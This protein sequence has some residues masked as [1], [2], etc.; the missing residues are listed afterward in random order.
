[1]RKKLNS[2]RIL[3]F[4][5]S[6]ILAVSNVSV[7]HATDTVSPADN[8]A[9]TPEFKRVSIDQT[10]QGAWEGTYGSDAAILLGYAYPGS[11]S[12]DSTTTSNMDFNRNNFNYVY[13]AESCSYF[14]SWAYYKEAENMRAYNVDQDSDTILNMPN[15]EPYTTYNKIES[16]FKG[17]YAT[18]DI[19]GSSV[20]SGGNLSG[21]VG[22]TD[23][24]NSSYKL[25]AYKFTLTDTESHLFSIYGSGI[26]ENEAVTVYFLSENGT[27]LLLKDTITANT[28]D[29]GAYVT[30]QV[31]GSFVLVTKIKGAYDGINGF[32]LDTNSEND[33][34][35]SSGDSGE[36]GENDDESGTPSTAIDYAV[37]MGI[38]TETKGAWEGKY[39][40]DVAVLYGYQAIYSDHTPTSSGN[41]LLNPNSYDYTITK[42]NLSY[43]FT[44]S[45]NCAGALV[46][47][48]PDQTDTAI[49]NMPSGITRDKFRAYAGSSGA[50]KKTTYTLTFD[51]TNPHLVSLYG[52]YTETTGN[53]TVTIID[54]STSNILLTDAISAITFNEGAYVTYLVP[55]SVQIEISKPAGKTGWYAFSGTFIDAFIDNKA[56]NLNA[57]AGT[58]ARSIKLSWTEA[59][60]IAEGAQVIIER[61]S[62]NGTD[63]SGWEQI[64]TVDAGVKEYQDTSLATGCSYTYR[65]TTKEVWAYSLPGSEVSYT[66]ASYASSTLTFTE[67][68]YGAKD[69]TEEVNMVISLINANEEPIS[70][71]SVSV[72]VDFNHDEQDLGSFSTDNVGKIYVDFTPRYL[73][74]ATIKASFGD[75]DETQLMGTEVAASLYVGEKEF[76]SAPVLYRLSDAV[77]PDDLISI[78]GYGLKANDMDDVKIWYAP[79]TTDDVAAQ[80]GTNAAELVKVQVDERDGYFIVTQLPKNAE[81]GLYDIWVQNEYGYSQPLVLNQARPLFISEYEAWNGQ[82]IRLSGRALQ[83]EQ[84]GYA[85]TTKVR[86]INGTQS[87]EQSVEALTPYSLTFRVGDVPLGTYQVEV[88]N[89]NGVTYRGLDSDQTLTV[90]NVGKDPLNIGVAWMDH[91]AWDNQFDVTDYGASGSDTE[92]DTAAINKAIEAATSSEAQ[93]GIIYIPDGTYHIKSIAVPANIVILGQSKT[94]T[95]LT[96]TGTGENMFQTAA[97]SKEIGHN[98]FARFSIRLSVDTT[99]PDAFFWLGQSWDGSQSDVATRKAEEFFLKEIDISYSFEVTETKRGITAVVIGNERYIVQD[100]DFAGYW[101][102]MQDIKVNAYTYYLRNS[103]EYVSA[104]VNTQASYAFIEE[105]VVTGGYNKGYDVH[106]HGIFGTQ[107]AHFENNTVKEVGHYAVNDGEAFC[108]EPPGGYE[109]YGDVINSS[110]DSVTY[111]PEAGV[112]SEHIALQYGKLHIQ[113][114]GG[115][116]MGQMREVESWDIDTNTV[117]ITEDWDVI[118]DS[119]S[120]ISI[121]S[122]LENF[123]VY[124]NQMEDCLKG[125]YFYG[126]VM[127]GVASNNVGKNTEGIYVHTSQVN[128]TRL[129]PCYYISIR[130]NILTGVSPAKQTCNISVRT[131]RACDGADYNGVMGYSVEIRDNKMTGIK[132]LTVNDCTEAPSFSGIILR[133]LSPSET[134]CGDTTNVLVENNYLE[135][136]ECAIMADAGYYG[137]LL[138]GNRIADDVDVALNNG[139]TVGTGLLTE[140]TVTDADSQKAI[141][142]QFVNVWDDVDGTIYTEETY[143]A[144]QN[145][146]TQ[147]NTVLNKEDA[148]SDELASALQEVRIASGRLVY[149]TELEVIEVTVDNVGSETYGVTVTAPTNGWVEGTNTF[150]VSSDNACVV[151][152]KN[153]NGAY[154]RVEATETDTPGAYSYTVDGMTAD[155]EITVAVAGDV[156]GDGQVNA[157]DAVQVRAASLGKITMSDI[158]SLTGDANGDGIINAIDAVMIRATSLGKMSL[159]W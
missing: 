93:G 125:I 88:S 40:N 43:A 116:G 48:D 34:S 123:T 138:K 139:N 111:I 53:M 12:Y 66:I 45:Y 58:E 25:A 18:E 55:G 79:H 49:L 117:K 146:I 142:A 97:E 120:R 144:L 92:D 155:T 119:T 159:E 41:V 102:S 156:N 6:L 16:F 86:L 78:N 28:F 71:Q 85:S 112:M 154:T 147:A 118:P 46:C 30:Y 121:N 54:Q 108:V 114:V 38:D 21:L 132:G 17:Q 100:C 80:P 56:D 73:G 152:V 151:A 69:T 126:Y 95:I 141:L 84:F 37:R 145:A 11:D 99:R 127:D 29:T 74:E 106:N 128:G 109:N 98:G 122:P 72:V 134:Y 31:S 110:S 33:E 15:V 158:Y 70:G 36:S 24:Y 150:T 13:Q 149:A 130:E 10:T 5:L 1:M 61:K 107:N 77:L 131:N 9:S 51:D 96:Y 157:V 60:D 39:G 27:E 148:T 129:M 44:H 101:A 105:C 57:E 14:S 52:Y 135:T 113:I 82:T 133:S 50:N 65:L 136:L 62:S 4:L 63:E 91:F 137:V 81:P 20:V 140:M 47:N 42:D 67:D 153:T 124:N 104:K 7:V 3:S 115:K 103:W 68:E 35:V 59:S 23:L 22:E 32:F 75:N 8:A 143:L 26:M 90:V 87:Y 83:G 19:W 94:G 89:D 64:A 2:I 76:V